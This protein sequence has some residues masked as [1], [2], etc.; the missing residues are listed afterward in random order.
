MWRNVIL[1][2]Q[3]SRNFFSP[4]LFFFTWTMFGLRT[5]WTHILCLEK[6]KKHFLPV[7]NSMQDRSTMSHCQ[8]TELLLLRR[9][10]SRLLMM[11]GLCFG[12]HTR[13]RTC[14]YGL[15]VGTW[16]PCHWKKVRR[17]QWQH[18]PT[19]WICYLLLGHCHNMTKFQVDRR[20]LQ[21]SCVCT[22]LLSPFWGFFNRFKWLYGSVEIQR[23]VEEEQEEGR[24][25]V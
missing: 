19:G 20:I 12:C 17:R 18:Q 8:M 7:H 13:R 1:R 14:F 4:S 25:T 15:A 6:K 21:C 22:V 10:H 5:I 23:S 3:I 11:T 16:W 24:A 2:P 9:H